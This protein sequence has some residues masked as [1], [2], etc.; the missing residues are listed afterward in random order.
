MAPPTDR[1]ATRR[2]P[3]DLEAVVRTLVDSRADYAWERW[4]LPAEGWAHLP[5]L[6]R[7]SLELLGF[8]HG[9][10]WSVGEVDSVAVWVPTDLDDRI[11]E[12]AAA[13]LGEA[14]V[15]ALG[16]RA[17]LVDEV[18]SLV[19]AASVPPARWL[20]ATMGT[21]P[22]WQGQGLGAAVLAPMLDQFDAERAAA[23]V[24]TSSER[25]VAFYGRAGFEVVAALDDLPHGAPPVWV[26]HRSPR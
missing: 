25:N 3:D 4:A 26:L 18:E 19:A 2:G 10:V 1:L 11:D 21:R 23:R 8:P 15:R 9:Q 14:A 20:L 22:N 12:P 13:D 24:E 17:A 16:E 7:R 5:D 6:F